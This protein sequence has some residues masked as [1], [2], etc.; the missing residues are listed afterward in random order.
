MTYLYEIDKNDFITLTEIHSQKIVAKD[1]KEVSIV[2]KN[3]LAFEN[4]EDGSSVDLIEYKVYAADRI[5]SI[6]SFSGEEFEADKDNYLKKNERAKLEIFKSI[7]EKTK[8]R[9]QK[10]VVCCQGSK[11]YDIH[12]RIIKRYSLAE[13]FLKTFTASHIY[14]QLN[15]NIKFPSNLKIAFNNLGTVKSFDS[16]PCESGALRYELKN[17]II[18]PRQGFVI[19]VCKA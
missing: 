16:V 1:K 12:K 4:K 19:G 14:K 9:K 11:S 2:S 10:Y 17:S 3:A 5:D 15:V 8:L 13:N 7:N 18:F 6:I